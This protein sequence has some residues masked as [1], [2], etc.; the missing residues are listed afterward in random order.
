[1]KQNFG[2]GDFQGI[3]EGVEEFYILFLVFLAEG[4]KQGFFLLLQREGQFQVVF[5]VEFVIVQNVGERK[6]YFKERRVKFG[7]GSEEFSFSVLEELVLVETQ[8][9]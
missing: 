6:F 5:V 9:K 8:G 4:G 1:M 2:E 7:R 3:G